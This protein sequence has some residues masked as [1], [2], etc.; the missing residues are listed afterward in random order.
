MGLRI[1]SLNNIR[2]EQWLDCERCGRRYPLSWLVYNYN[3][4]T[5]KTPLVCVETCDDVPAVPVDWVAH[6]KVPPL[7]PLPPK[8]DTRGGEDN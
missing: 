4:A 3:P 2:G 8:V 6:G 7:P 5:G 1:R